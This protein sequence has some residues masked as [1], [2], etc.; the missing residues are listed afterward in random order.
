MKDN[1]A[2]TT[3]TQQQSCF[4]GFL[5]DWVTLTEEGKNRNNFLWRRLKNERKTSK[6][7]AEYTEEKP[8]PFKQIP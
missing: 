3:Q 4:W 6:P 1:T 2:D 8:A 7:K 5:Q